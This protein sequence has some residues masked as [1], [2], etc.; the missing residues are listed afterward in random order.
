M[1]A[2]VL[3]IPRAC[4]TRQDDQPSPLLIAAR[5]LADSLAVSLATLRRMDSS[6]RLPRPIRLSNGAVRWRADEIRAWVEADCPR[7]SEWEAFRASSN[8]S[9]RLGGRAS[10]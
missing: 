2:D 8:E 7:R 4:D 9:A 10:R 1:S 3:P 6:G 5:P